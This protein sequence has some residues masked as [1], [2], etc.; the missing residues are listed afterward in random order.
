MWKNKTVISGIHFPHKMYRTV[1][2]HR[3]PTSEHS[4]LFS[5][6]P[7]DNV[8]CESEILNPEILLGDKQRGWRSDHRDGCRIHPSPVDDIHRGYDTGRDNIGLLYLACGDK[9]IERFADDILQ[10]AYRGRCF[11]AR[12]TTRIGLFLL[13]MAALLRC[14]RTGL[15]WTCR[16]SRQRNANSRRIG[17]ADVAEQE[18]ERENNAVM[19][20]CFQVRI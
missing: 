19:E 17:P 14:C 10:R 9:D 15:H 5:G 6:N 20:I 12:W 18:Y 11:H 2:P 1:V 16:G 7:E 3:I 13:T 4:T 8:N